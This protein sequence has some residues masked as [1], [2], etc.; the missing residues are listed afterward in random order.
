MPLCQYNIYANHAFSI[1]VN[2]ITHKGLIQSQR[3]T[4]WSPK[5]NDCQ[6]H[7]QKRRDRTREKI[8]LLNPI[9]ILDTIAFTLVLSKDLPKSK[10]K[11][12]QSMLLTSVL[13][14]DSCLQRE[15]RALNAS[16]RTNP[17]TVPGLFQSKCVCDH[18]V[19]VK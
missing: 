10:L 15:R 18:H 16:R 4:A 11:V 13:H 19:Q 1:C 14:S 3:K 2:F 9:M 5:T 8:K 17:T 6:G 7:L 12:L